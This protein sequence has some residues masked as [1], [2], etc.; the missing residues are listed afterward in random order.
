M[1]F[2][3]E[4]GPI[5]KLRCVFFP[6]QTIPPKARVWVW[7]CPSLVNAPACLCGC[8]CSGCSARHAVT[9]AGSPPKILSKLSH[10][11]IHMIWC[12][13]PCGL[14]YT[15]QVDSCTL[16]NFLNKILNY[17]YGRKFLTK[18]DRCIIWFLVL[19]IY[20]FHFITLLV[21]HIYIGIFKTL[22][23]ICIYSFSLLFLLV[24]GLEIDWL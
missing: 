3:W 24:V 19:C 14:F 4:G 11:V 13:A 7:C 6:M 23:E 17:D 8:V 21:S 22:C 1:N 12:D 9:P 20:I 16:Y 5:D 18:Y 2:R 15:L 10:Q